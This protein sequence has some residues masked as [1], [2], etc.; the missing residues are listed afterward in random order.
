MLFLVTNEELGILRSTDGGDT[1][2]TLPVESDVKRVAISD[3]FATDRTLFAATYRG[4]LFQSF[5]LGHTWESFQAHDCEAVWSSLEESEGKSFRDFN[6]GILDVCFFPGSVEL[7]AS[8]ERGQFAFFGDNSGLLRLRVEDSTLEDL[9]VADLDEVHVTDLAISPSFSTDS[10]VFLSTLGDGVFRSSDGGDSWSAVDLGLPS[11]E[12]GSVAISPAFGI[13]RTLFAGSY[14]EGVLKSV[15]GGNSWV[16]MN[17]GLTN[18]VVLA[19]ELSPDFS[20]DGIVFASTE[21]GVFTSDDGGELWHL[22]FEP[23]IDQVPPITGT[24]PAPVVTFE[25]V[26]ESAEHSQWLADVNPRQQTVVQVLSGKIGV[27]FPAGSRSSPFLAEVT[28]IDVDNVSERLPTGTVLQFVRVVLYDEGIPAE[29]AELDSPATLR[30]TLGSNQV[31]ALGGP[32]VVLATHESGGFTLL[33]RRVP[34]SPWTE[35][36]FELTSGPA[37]G[38]ITVSV[39]VDRFSD[40]VVV[41]DE[42]VLREAETQLAESTTAPEPTATKAPG[43]TPTA[44]PELQATQ[45]APSVTLQVTLTPEPEPTET[46]LTA[47]TDALAPTM[48]ATTSEVDGGGGGFPGWAVVV[49][50]VGAVGVVLL[51]WGLH[52]RWGRG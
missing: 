1:W 27:T 38:E 2:N 50:L 14:R 29:D 48:E 21:E 15:D 36:P 30:M 37:P 7:S 33:S 49:I 9:Q 24:P 10:T 4:D 52:S 42:Q 16:P 51:A 46:L 34:E 44:T 18:L 45:P 17:E 5:D 41:V 25:E 22:V 26:V 19:I 13:D 43:V 20:N 11:D 35:I 32:D 8:S 3:R 12:I 47:P 28:V 6:V 40:F 23:E 39:E 31:E